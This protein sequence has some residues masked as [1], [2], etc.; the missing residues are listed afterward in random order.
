MMPRYSSRLTLP[1]CRMLAATWNVQAESVLVVT[2]LAMNTAPQTSRMAASRSASV[3]KAPARTQASEGAGCRGLVSKILLDQRLELRERS[4]RYFVALRDQR[5]CQRLR[6]VAV[7]HR[8]QALQQLRDGSL[9]ELRVL[10]E[11]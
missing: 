6:A 2:G 3:C 11:G 7:P 8:I 4:S 10:V 9:G 1:C 5:A